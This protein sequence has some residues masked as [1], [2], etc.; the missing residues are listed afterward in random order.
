MLFNCIECNGQISQYAESCPHCGLPKDRLR[1]HLEK[2]VEDYKNLQISLELKKAE[3]EK[4][5][6]KNVELTKSLMKF[7]GPSPLSVMPHLSPYTK[8]AGEE[9]K[10]E[11]EEK[12]N[13][14]IEQEKATI[15]KTLL[16]AK[17]M[18]KEKYPST[19]IK[20]YL[21]EQKEKILM[22][23]HGSTFLIHDDE[24]IK[25]I[26][27]FMMEHGYIASPKKETLWDKVLERL[28]D[29]SGYILII[30][31]GVILYFVLR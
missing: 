17:Q 24:A 20:S 23:K 14:R 12:E 28:I 4:E 2:A 10:K 18:Q 16:K 26:Q 15:K 7:P 11:W 25:P 3:E 22:H 1:P 8:E 27:S 30:L 19:A 9:L 5:H 29:L 31:V 13:K 6:R 21:R